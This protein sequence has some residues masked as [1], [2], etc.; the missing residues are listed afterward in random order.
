MYFGVY[1]FTGDSAALRRS[2]DSLIDHFAD[3]VILNLCVTTTDGI[4][5]YDTCP[6]R[7]EFEAFARSPLF[8]AALDR[9]GLPE[10]TVELI[11]AVHA[12]AAKV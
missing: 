5:V 7:E 9:A 12:A 10:P 4:S 3:E 6:S 1:H 11:G 8:R 2:Y